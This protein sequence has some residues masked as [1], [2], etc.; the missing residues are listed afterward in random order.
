MSSKR[1]VIK[2]STLLTGKESSCYG[3]SMKVSA[4]R[5][6]ISGSLIFL[7]AT[8]AFAFAQTNFGQQRGN[9]ERMKHDVVTLTVTPPVNQGQLRSCQVRESLF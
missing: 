8:P 7:L 1:N 9:Q 6:A 5:I 3:K 4:A 2:L